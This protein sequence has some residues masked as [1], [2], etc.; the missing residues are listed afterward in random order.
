MRK[1]LI[2]FLIVFLLSFLF[3]LQLLAES[4]VE[5]KRAEVNKLKNELSS[6]NNQI[7]KIEEE[8]ISLTGRIEGVVKEIHNAENQLTR[9]LKEIED[10]KE[11]LSKRARRTYIE[12]SDYALEM[13]LEAENFSN[14]LSRAKLLYFLIKM[15]SQIVEKLTAAE[16]ETRELISVLEQNKNNYEI[17][18][19]EYSKRV[20][21][22]KALKE[23]KAA[24]L[25]K[26]SSELKALLEIE[27]SRIE[28][29]SRGAPRELPPYSSNSV[30]PRKFVE[31]SPYGGGWLTSQR[32]PDTYSSTGKRWTCV[33]SWYGNQF[34]GR[35]TAS[36]EVFNQWDFTVA[37]R[38]LPFGTFVAIERDGRKIV[39]KVTDRGPFIAGR[40]FD[41]SRACAEALGFSGL[42]SIKV[43]IIK[44]IH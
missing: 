21:E 23:T 39:A 34:H 25:S 8:Q 29:S 33:A 42:A 32:M 17:Y 9:L 1:V 36:G 15:D 14:F 38:T 30:V 44:P 40:E 13:I 16:N 12:G 26:S 24:M 41:L 28:L 3:P 37:H 4:Q 19:R 6:I 7:R 10:Q 20:E 27:A 31:V 2:C 11:A 43:E 22:L 35:K 5:I 18:K